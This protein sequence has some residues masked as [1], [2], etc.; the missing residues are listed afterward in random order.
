M[1]ESDNEDEKFVK[2]VINELSA[3]Q[4]SDKNDDTK[5]VIEG[6][7]GGEDSG[8]VAKV[9]NEPSV[10]SATAK[11]E[12]GQNSKEIGKS[13]TEASSDPPKPPS[14]IIR[15]SRPYNPSS[16]RTTISSVTPSSSSLSSSQP[17]A[18]QNGTSASN[19]I[20]TSGVT[21]APGSRLAALQ[22]PGSPMQRILARAQSPA[23][24][25]A[26]RLTR[27]ASSESAKPP[28]GVRFFHLNFNTKSTFKL[29]H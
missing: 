15:L 21:G 12:E 18:S 24:A 23:L 8:D 13:I 10:T 5:D 25:A 28:P 16:S 20:T 27:Q 6:A 7:V 17:P 22:R 11:V 2:N 4:K 14:R 9:T 26:A 19:T 1:A 3:F 29:A